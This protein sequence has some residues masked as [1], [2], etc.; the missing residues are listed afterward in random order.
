MNDGCGRIGPQVRF[1][2]LSGQ[3]AYGQENEENKL[4]QPQQENEKIV[5]E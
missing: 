1:T 3:S 4:K 2:P 5:M